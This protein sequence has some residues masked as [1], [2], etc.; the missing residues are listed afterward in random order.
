MNDMDVKAAEIITIAVVSAKY[1]QN[2]YER[3]LLAR[4][5]QIIVARSDGAYSSPFRT[6]RKLSASATC[7]A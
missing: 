3:A 7:R 5:P 1:F 6:P 2:H 4:Q